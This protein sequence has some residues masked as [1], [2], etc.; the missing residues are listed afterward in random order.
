[1]KHLKLA[2]LSILFAIVTVLSARFVS[3]YRIELAQDKK[4]SEIGA[5]ITSEVQTGSMT[6][7]IES[8]KSLFSLTFPQNLPIVQIK[9]QN[10]I[11]GG[12]PSSSDIR[13]YRKIEYEIEA[14][15]DITVTFYVQKERV[16][17]SALGRSILVTSVVFFLV[18]TL[19]GW[20]ARRISLAAQKRFNTEL[21]QA[22][23]LSLE[24]PINSRLGQFFEKIAQGGSGGRNLKKSIQDLKQKIIEQNRLAL[25]TELELKKNEKFIEVVRQVRHDIRSPLQTLIVLSDDEF[26]SPSL[27]RHMT[28]VISSI[29]NLIEDLEIKEEMADSSELGLK[30]HVAEALIK[31]VIQQRRLIYGTTQIELKINSEF[32]TVV[33]INPHHF[34]RVIGNLIQNAHEAIVVKGGQGK[35]IIETH[36]ENGKLL[37]EVRDNGIGISPEVQAKLFTPGFTHGKIG[38]S[39]L[40]LSHA[41][42]CI[43]RWNGEISIAPNID[44]GTTVSIAIPQ[45][46]P[47]ARYVAQSPFRNP[48][49]SVIVDDNPSDF[50]R[51]QGALEG[52]TVYCSNIKEFES[53]FSSV[54]D[55]NGVQVI[56]DYNLGENRTGLDILEDLPSDHPRILSTN[57][58]D[59]SRVLAASTE[60][61]YVLPKVFLL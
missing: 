52:P 44:G 60:G 26:S 28:S 37:I 31:E 55:K 17:A 23:G 57:D 50:A 3:I 11:Y 58:Y 43:L 2:S 12:D 30:L 18:L 49:V 41:K 25:A 4:A 35:I 34:R 13:D 39:G 38:G 36:Q 20:S 7:A 53:W 51:L 14:R 54:P 29:N 24:V 21:Q 10:R 42:S 48:R 9:E 32:L 59:D 27:Q 8:A 15:S 19:L 22:L 46:L 40:G 1:M 47:H 61:V 45:A 56:F 16:F 33:Q 6:K 5:I